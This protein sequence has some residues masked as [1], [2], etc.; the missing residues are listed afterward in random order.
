MFITL[1]CIPFYIGNPKRNPLFLR[2]EDFLGFFPEPFPGAI[3]TA[4]AT[5]TAIIIAIIP[6]IITVT[7]AT[8]ISN[9][10][11]KVKALPFGEIF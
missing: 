6:F 7:T 8:V 1:I 5:P 3:T 11:T 9:T 10:P 2:G 4:A